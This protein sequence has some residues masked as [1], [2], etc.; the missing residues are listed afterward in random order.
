MDLESI[1]KLTITNEYK[2]PYNVG[3]CSSF[4]ILKYDAKYDAKIEQIQNI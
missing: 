2:K 4:L 1:K 3:Y